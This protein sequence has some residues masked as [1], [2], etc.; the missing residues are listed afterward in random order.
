MI[1]FAV[2]QMPSKSVAARETT[3]M[4]SYKTNSEIWDSFKAYFK[5][6]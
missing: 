1:C 2:L 6:V 4:L 3:E 5:N